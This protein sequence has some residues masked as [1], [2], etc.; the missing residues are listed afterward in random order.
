MYI[1]N[2]ALPGKSRYCLQGLHPSP[3]HACVLC[4]TSHDTA[5]SSMNSIFPLPLGAGAGGSAHSVSPIHLLIGSQAVRQPSFSPFLCPWAQ[6]RA[7]GG[8]GA[9]AQAHPG[10]QPGQACGL[11]PR[12]RAAAAGGQQAAG[13]RR[14]G[15]GAAPQPACVCV[16]RV[17]RCVR[18]GRGVVWHK[19]EVS[20]LPG[21]T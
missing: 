6:A 13:P 21:R 15:P 3:L 8:A 14:A 7:A 11:S 10:T 17:R 2:H 1:F 18:R 4:S 20:K 16:G 5:R 9:A 19:L 12:G